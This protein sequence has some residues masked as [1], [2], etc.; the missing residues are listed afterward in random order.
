[1]V[2]RKENSSEIN[3]ESK[4]KSSKEESITS[5][6]LI[7]GFIAVNIIFIAILIWGL[8]WNH[9]TIENNQ[10]KILA[11]YDSCIAEI[12]N[13]TIKYPRKDDYQIQ[14]LRDNEEAIKSILEQG[15]SKIQSEYE[16]VEIWVGIITVVFLI[17]SFYSLF[18]SESLESDSRRATDHIRAMANQWDDKVKEY[19]KGVS[20]L[21]GKME[22]ELSDTKAARETLKAY[23]DTQL[24][25]KS[26]EIIKKNKAEITKVTSNLQQ[27]IQNYGER[28][29]EQLN[30]IEDLRKKFEESINSYEE[31]SPEE[32]EKMFNGQDSKGKKD[33]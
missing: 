22:K 24:N 31:L 6:K 11:K 29:Q 14:K 25:K 32:I 17:F 27:A 8:A 15:Y 28:L 23:Y 33:D 12:N 3:K 1:M 26:D 16:S 5:C 19:E 10:E 18:K 13:D 20:S 9:N 4:D 2:L 21:K 7:Y 30:E